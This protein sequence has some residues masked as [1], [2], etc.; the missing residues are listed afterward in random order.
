[1]N[2]YE[3]GVTIDGIS[4]GCE[5]C[6]CIPYRIDSNSNSTI[7]NDILSILKP[8]TLL[9]CNL[10]IKNSS[11]DSSSNDKILFRIM[12][13]H[14]H[15]SK[16][17][18][19]DDNIIRLFLCSKQLLEFINNTSNVSSV[20][21]D[22][23]ASSVSNNQYCLSFNSF[24]Y[25]NAIDIIK[26]N[27]YYDWYKV[28]TVKYIRLTKTN[29]IKTCYNK[30]QESLLCIDDTSPCC[31]PR[32]LH[33]KMRGSLIS[34]KEKTL[35]ISRGYNN[36]RIFYYAK[37]E[38]NDTNNINNDYSYAQITNSTQIVII[39]EEY[40]IESTL[41]IDNSLSIQN[42]LMSL[43]EL[44]DPFVMSLVKGIAAA[45]FNNNTTINHGMTHSILLESSCDETCSSLLSH[46]GTTFNVPI[47]RLT[48]GLIYGRGHEHADFLLR[49]YL[50][51]ALTQEP[52]II[53]F[54][55][56]DVLVPASNGIAEVTDTALGI[57]KVITILLSQFS[58]EYKVNDKQKVVIVARAINISNVHSS[59]V[60]LFQEQFPIPLPTAK[61]RRQIS[62]IIL[63]RMPNFS[64]E[65]E[66]SY[67]DAVYAL[68]DSLVGLSLT[69][70][71]KELKEAI[72]NILKNKE[73]TEEN[74]NNKTLFKEVIGHDEI[75]RILEESILLPRKYPDILR[76]FSVRAD[77]GI[78]FFGPPGTGKTLFPKAISRELK[79]PLII[80]HISDVIKAEIGA[81][82]KAVIRTFAEA[83]KSAPCIV[84]IDEFQAMFSSRASSKG[85]WNSN[86]TDEVGSSLSSTL[87]SCFDDINNWNSN[88]GNE[89]L[90]T[91][92]AATN[93]PWAIDSGFLR[94]GRF[95]RVLFVGPLDEDG[96][97]SFILN[98]L[99][100]VALRLLNSSIDY[101]EIK[102]SEWF[103]RVLHDTEGYTGADLELLKIRSF[104]LMKNDSTLDVIQ[105]NIMKC[106]KESKP[107]TLQDDI[108]LY[109]QWNDTF[110][111]LR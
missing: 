35:V 47:I 17:K 36:E 59:I 111:R 30:D 48:A 83:R 3:I 42:S 108:E 25:N 51:A 76:K 41:C 2:K 7:T 66:V 77:A 24:Q 106:L 67:I 95:D 44:H 87:A 104:R 91:I 31:Q 27:I 100:Y 88:A 20:S 78:L 97:S 55:D 45:M 81:G 10:N 101:D 74:K 63:N 65:K 94:A 85:N 64:I 62:R 99:S 46:I 15:I 40:L 110:G 16:Y 50:Q 103:E 56:I 5:N 33:N 86:D 71:V 13:I 19:I 105:E 29:K 9:W 93:E 32:I 39:S 21:N 6:I 26:E 98:T 28:P 18:H 89:S 68:S 58:N 72:P 73:L 11:H 69:S 1:M 57:M 96:R 22:S 38:V 12:T 102:A 54:D 79:C 92:I 53:Y 61:H 70:L 60:K 14:S 109:S 52:C 84:F 8:G 80:M 107:S 37:V 23:N 90:V 34:L 49:N 4:I 75:K 82:E 43:E